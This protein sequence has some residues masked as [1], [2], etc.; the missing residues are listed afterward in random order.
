MLMKVINMVDVSEGDMNHFWPSK[1]R[2][3][4]RDL[5]PENVN[6]EIL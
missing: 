6:V 5:H 3:R 1:N 2:I 4:Y